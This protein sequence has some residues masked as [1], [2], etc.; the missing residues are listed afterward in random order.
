MHICLYTTVID[1]SILS[2][3]RGG[4]ARKLVLELLEALV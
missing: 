4:A 2:E 1:L 3:G